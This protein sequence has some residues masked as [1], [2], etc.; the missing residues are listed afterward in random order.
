[1]QARSG[2]DREPAALR[3]CA[4]R[5]LVAVDQT[6]AWLAFVCRN[7]E[8]DSAAVRELGVAAWSHQLTGVGVGLAFEQERGDTT[9]ECVDLDSVCCIVLTRG[10]G[11][12]RDVLAY[13]FR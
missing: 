6:K 4:V 3:R 1:M 7:V 2:G 11:Q 5:G 13:S 8:A 10:G 9:L 12:A